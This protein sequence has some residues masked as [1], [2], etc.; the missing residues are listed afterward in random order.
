MENIIQTEG[1]H[2]TYKST[3]VE[4][5]AL[6]GVS[7]DVKRGEFIA[8]MGPSGSGK[9]T[10]FNILGCLDNP[11]EG[12]YVLEEEN[13]SDLSETEVAAIRNSKIG[14]VFQ[15]FNLLPKARA[16]ENVELPLVFAKKRMSN[17]VK[18]ELARTALYKVGLE[19]RES[20]YPSQLSG[21]EQQRVAIA[22]AI[23]ND[24]LIILADEPTGNLDTQASQ[25]IMK[26]FD[27]LNKNGKTI[28][29]ITHEP[30]IARCSRRILY[31]RDGKILNDSRIESPRSNTRMIEDSWRN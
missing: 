2:K 21:G 19:G 17:K 29:V 13:I 3:E 1:I 14:F 23:V 15:S 10:L 5:Q 7:L 18:R 8:I 20:H 30:D 28:M 4:V 26:I 27:A 11:T 12:S 16:I 31:F 22:R 6:K 25:E 24:P 9:S